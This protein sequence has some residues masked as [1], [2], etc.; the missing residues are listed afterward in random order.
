MLAVQTKQE[1]NIFPDVGSDANALFVPHFG[2][3]RQPFSSTLDKRQLYG[4]ESCYEVINTLQYAL[5]SG[6]GIT[7]ITGPSGSGKTFITTNVL[8]SM[9]DEFL[10]V[11]IPNPT[12]NFESLLRSVLDEMCIEYHE[13]LDS[14]QL[15]RLVNASLYYFYAQYKQPVILSIDNAERMPLETLAALSFINN[16]ETQYRKLV[17]IVL[18]GSSELEQKLSHPSLHALSQRISFTAQL[19]PMN[20]KETIGYVRHRLHLSGADVDHLFPKK[21]I[22]TL[23]KASRGLPRLVNLLSYKAMMLAYGMGVSQVTRKHIR[24]AES[25]TIIESKKQWL[26]KTSKYVPVGLFLVGI[27]ALVIRYATLS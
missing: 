19:K 12:G 26:H 25:D 1:A 3:T 20:Q 21:T 14:Q 6:E 9:G 18:V 11:K 27:S 2:L 16:L 8:A 10:V 15:L 22:K 17:Q 13:N 4:Y 23:Y 7:K 5:R 24:F